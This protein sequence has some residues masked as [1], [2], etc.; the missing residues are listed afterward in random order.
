M[1]ASPQRSTGRTFEGDFR[2]IKVS[3]VDA[4]TPQTIFTPYS[5]KFGAPVAGNKIFVSCTVV[6]NGFE[7]GSIV[8]SCVVS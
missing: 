5:L 1:R 7:S 6:L 3:A 2:L 4:T 8:S